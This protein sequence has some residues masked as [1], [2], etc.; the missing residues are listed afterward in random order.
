MEKLKENFIEDENGVKYNTSSIKSVQIVKTQYLSQDVEPFYRL[1]KGTEVRRIFRRNIHFKE[2]GFML[3]PFCDAGYGGY[4]NRYYYSVKDMVNAMKEYWGKYPRGGYYTFL[5]L[6]EYKAAQN[7]APNAE[8]IEY[9]EEKNCILVKP[10]V[11]IF[12]DDGS[13]EHCCWAHR[14]IEPIV[15]IFDTDEEAEQYYN[16]FN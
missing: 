4:R 12:V 13:T 3:G 8:C 6:A 14:E 11:K 9:C 15:K 16:N 5:P 1:E 10:H 2:D 7:I